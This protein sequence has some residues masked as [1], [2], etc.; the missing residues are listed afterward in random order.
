[1][2]RR[3]MGPF[4]DVAYAILMTIWLLCMVALCAAMLLSGCSPYAGAL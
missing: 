3:R 4:V 1:M 2:K